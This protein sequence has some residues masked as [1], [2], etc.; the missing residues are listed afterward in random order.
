M[1]ATLTELPDDDELDNST[2][3]SSSTTANT[4]D[5]STSE[6]CRNEQTLGGSSPENDDDT[7]PL[8]SVN[9]LTWSREELRVS[10][11]RVSIE[12]IMSCVLTFFESFVQ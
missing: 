10:S 4:L 5:N 11:L 12:C 7:T 2:P 8:S 3:T 1:S 6:P 9:S